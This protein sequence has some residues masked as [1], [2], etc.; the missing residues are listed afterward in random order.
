MS[1][2]GVQTSNIAVET[3][4]MLGLDVWGLYTESLLGIEIIIFGVIYSWEIYS[5]SFSSDK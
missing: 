1:T 4:W 5:Y 3:G 2:K